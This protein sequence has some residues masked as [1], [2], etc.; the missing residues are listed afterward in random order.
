MSGYL[1]FPNNLKDIQDHIQTDVLSCKIFFRLM[2]TVFKE[3]LH[4]Q[5]P[6]IL[7]SSIRFAFE[8]AFFS[9]QIAENRFG[10]LP[11][12]SDKFVTK[13]NV[14]SYMILQF[15]LKTVWKISKPY[16]MTLKTM[17]R[18]S[19]GKAQCLL[20]PLQSMGEP[21]PKKALHGEIN[22]FGQVFQGMFYIGTNYQIM[23]GGE[24]MVKRF[25]R[26]SQ[27]SFSSH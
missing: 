2:I 25:Q 6:L 15:R 17:A 3:K 26:S 7:Y 23:Q 9:E 16:C 13:F 22:L 24:L 19:D 1:Y 4:L 5:L 12:I 8:T 14:F 11:E 21:F 27:V 20:S 10:A 18:G